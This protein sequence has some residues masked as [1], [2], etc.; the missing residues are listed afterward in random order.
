MPLSMPRR[1]LVPGVMS[2][3]ET[4]PF[5]QQPQRLRYFCN[6]L[7]VI[8]PRLSHPENQLGI[9]NVLGNACIQLEENQY[10]QG[11]D[12]KKPVHDR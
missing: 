9:K 10:V 4:G 11:H 2:L 7:Q 8:R 12:G 5:L 3:H 6:L 1:E